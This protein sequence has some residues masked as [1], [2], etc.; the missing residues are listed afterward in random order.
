[1]NSAPFNGR[2]GSA[3]YLYAPMAESGGNRPGNFNETE[4]IVV[5][6]VV[7][8]VYIRTTTLVV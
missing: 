6:V 5:G 1:M 8:F 7:L 2:A 3:Q 4:T